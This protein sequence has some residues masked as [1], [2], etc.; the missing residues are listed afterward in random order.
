M[1]L[2]ADCFEVLL[3]DNVDKQEFAT[4]T[5]EDA[6]FEITSETTDVEG[7]GGLVAVLHSPRKEN[8]TLKDVRFHFDILAKQLG[9]DIAVAAGEAYAFPREYAV[10]TGK[11]ITLTHT[12][13]TATDLKLT[14]SAG[15]ALVVT[16]DYTLSGA[17]VTIVSED[18]EVGDIIKA[19]S[20]L[21]ATSATTETIEINNKK[22]PNGVT[23]V[24]QTL[25][26]AEDETPLND[27]QVVFDKCVFDGSITINTNTKRDA[28]RHDMNLKVLNKI[29]D[30]IA[31]RI[32]RIPIEA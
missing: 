29:C 24:L 22:Y 5:L 20:Y 21:F 23:C 26:I 31:G 17:E 7:G 8:I 6:G 14:D 4:A 13:K 18:I 27:I 2:I 3:I 32:V 9:A 30:D 11:K 1:A 19:G 25:E 15:V 12:P 28:M 10:A 16:T